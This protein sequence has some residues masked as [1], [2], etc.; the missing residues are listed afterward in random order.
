MS[1]ELVTYITLGSKVRLSKVKKFKVDEHEE[2]I[3]LNY[4]S[5]IEQ[6]LDEAITEAKGGLIVLLP[7]SSFP[8]IESR[9]ILKKISLVNVSAWGWFKH[10]SKRK[11]IA[12]NIGKITTFISG[13]PSLE[14]GLYFSRRLYFS[15]GGLGMIGNS[16]FSEISKRLQSRLDPQKPLSP[17]SIR[18]KN[19]KLE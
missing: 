4:E 17:L 2:C 1:Q 8:S 3:H 7:P 18:T 15:V 12:Q 19:L 10:N 16:P 14:Q 5:S 13:V 9:E 6:S 11:N